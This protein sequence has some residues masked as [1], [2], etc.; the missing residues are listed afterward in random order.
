MK[1]LKYL[2]RILQICGT[3]LES[4]SLTIC[5]VFFILSSLTWGY[6]F[7]AIAEVFKSDIGYHNIWFLLID[8][9][10]VVIWLINLNEEIQIN[11]FRK[12]LIKFKEYA[13]E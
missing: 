5:W 8:C 3:K 7:L 6:H 10:N 12:I 1:V 4:K 13:S 11:N 2:Y 9:F